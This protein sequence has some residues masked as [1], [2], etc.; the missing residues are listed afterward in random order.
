MRAIHSTN[1]FIKFAQVTRSVVLYLDG[2]HHL[3]ASA[4]ADEFERL[5][6]CHQSLRRYTLTLRKWSTIGASLI[7]EHVDKVYV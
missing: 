7:V 1:N 4:A 3:Q 2:I 5:K 6:S